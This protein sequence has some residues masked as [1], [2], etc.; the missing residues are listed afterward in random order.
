MGTTHLELG[1]GVVHLRVTRVPH[2]NA[3]APLKP[4][5]MNMASFDKAGKVSALMRVTAKSCVCVC[6]SHTMTY[7][8]AG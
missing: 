4:D 7:A 8:A 3:D 5:N 2:L 6:V 1:E